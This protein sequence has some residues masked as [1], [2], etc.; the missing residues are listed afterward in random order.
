MLVSACKGEARSLRSGYK[1]LARHLKAARCE[2]RRLEGTGVTPEGLAG[3]AIVVLGGPTQPF[4]PEEAAALR[5]YLHSGGCLLALAGEGGGGGGS[6]AAGGGAAAGGASSAAS[7]ASLNALLACCGVGIEVAGD[8][9]I[10][11][12]FT[13]WVLGIVLGA[14]FRVLRILWH[15]CGR[16]Q[17]QGHVSAARSLPKSGAAQHQSF[18]CRC[19]LPV[20]LQVRPPQGGAG[21]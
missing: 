6:A 2:V 7:S 16:R 5:D 11:T 12:A 3:A 17:Q 4:A 19:P 1:A 18:G 9:V 13:K 20:R 10:Q 21:H 15:G 8:C 14:E